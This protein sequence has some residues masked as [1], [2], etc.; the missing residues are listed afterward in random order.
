MASLTAAVQALVDDRDGAHSHL[1]AVRLAHA[2]L[3]TEQG[4]VQTEL[5]AERLRSAAEIESLRQRIDTIQDERRRGEAEIEAER[6]RM[7]SEREQ[8]QR[9]AAEPFAGAQGSGRDRARGG[10]RRDSSSGRR[11][12]ECAARG[13]RSGGAEQAAR[14]ARLPTS[15][16]VGLEQL[17]TA[18][19]SI[20]SR[21]DVD[22][23]VGFVPPRCRRGGLACRRVSRQRRSP[24][25]LEDGRLSSARRASFR[26]GD[27]GR[28]HA[29]QSG[30]ER[31][32]DG[33]GSGSARADVCLGALTRRRWPSRSWWTVGPLRFS[34]PI[35][36]KR[37]RGAVATAWRT[38]LRRS[39]ASRR[40]SLALLTALRTVQALGVRRSGQW[41]SGRTGCA[42]IR[43]AAGLRDQVVQRGGRAHRT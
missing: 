33:L 25:L 9:E 15:R 26:R 34:T 12:V 43:A 2:E 3:E 24:A 41:R 5:E 6:R 11:R 16:G 42:A 29:R 18:M 10:A 19:Q 13:D 28:R 1:E 23:G 20:E 22:G 32:S 17:T 8:E 35:P 31:R 21:A 38:P 37:R 7:A 30:P 39:G 40:P 27:G 14:R 4:S 36:S